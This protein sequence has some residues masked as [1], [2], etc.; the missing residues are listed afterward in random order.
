MRAVLAA[1]PESG[2]AGKTTG[3]GANM[4]GPGR[5]LA[6][7]AAMVVPRAGT[8]V[9]GATNW[10]VVVVLK[11]GVNTRGPTLGPTTQAEARRRRG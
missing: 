2:Q 5:Q 7:P 9:A 4:T 10:T 8:S 1:P 3:P 6:T 11:A